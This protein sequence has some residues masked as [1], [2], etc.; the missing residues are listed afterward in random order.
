MSGILKDFLV[1][2]GV[3]PDDLSE[4]VRESRA[5][6]RSVAKWSGLLSRGAIHLGGKARAG[7]LTQK[8]SLLAGMALSQIEE[9]AGVLLGKRGNGSK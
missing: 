7:S 8:G 2:S 6:V 4:A 3:K 5:A 9:K 1:A